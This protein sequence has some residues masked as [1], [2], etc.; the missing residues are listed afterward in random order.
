[1]G[2]ADREAGP[3]RL[4]ARRVYL[5]R[6]WQDASDDFPVSALGASLRCGM[7]LAGPVSSREPDRGIRPAFLRLS[8]AERRHEADRSGARPVVRPD[9][10]G[11]GLAGLAVAATKAV[12]A[13]LGG[14]V[15]R[16]SGCPPG[17][18][19]EEGSLRCG[20][21]IEVLAIPEASPATS[22]ACASARC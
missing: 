11:P 14:Q 18:R 1:M 17:R 15:R 7:P 20:R 5:A 2:R 21:C 12:A 4:E 6:E 9:G 16:V 10:N 3:N 22:H 8:L 13:S 19:A